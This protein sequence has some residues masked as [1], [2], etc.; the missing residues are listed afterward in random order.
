[1]FFSNAF[2][3]CPGCS[4]HASGTPCL[5][6]L[7]F[8]STHALTYATLIIIWSF[9]NNNYTKKSTASSLSVFVILKLTKKLRTRTITRRPKP[10][11][12]HIRAAAREVPKSYTIDHYVRRV[13]ESI[14]LLEFRGRWSYVGFAI[15][16]RQASTQPCDSV[17]AQCCF[18]LVIVYL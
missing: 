15:D 17:T 7:R 1:M 13:P 8:A 6:A 3:V 16:V 18:K 10:T 11:H 4:Q 12:P 9:P 2:A 5:C 14:K